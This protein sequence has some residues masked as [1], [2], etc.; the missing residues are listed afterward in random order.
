MF[1]SSDTDVESQPERSLRLRLVGELDIA[2]SAPVRRALRDAFDRGARDIVLD[3]SAVSFMDAAAL[4]MLVGAHRL[5]T[6]AGGTL[7]LTE[8]QR[9][10]RRVLEVTAFDRVLLDS[11]SAAS[12]S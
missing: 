2:T 10:V 3:V 7:R 8:P 6:G 12:R 4:G 11:T 1:C 9:G 5:V